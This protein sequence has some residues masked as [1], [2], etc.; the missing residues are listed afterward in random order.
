MIDALREPDRYRRFGLAIPN[1]LLLY[2]P[3]GCGKTFIAER[4]GE[5]LGA[6]FGR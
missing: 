1:G 2:G 5:E 6:A 3:P 4:F